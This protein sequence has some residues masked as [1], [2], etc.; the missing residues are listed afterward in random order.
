MK[1]IEIYI[2]DLP[3]YKIV[4]ITPEKISMSVKAIDHV[5]NQKFFFLDYIGSI[6]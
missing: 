3:A 6:E 2:E 4:F 5:K 1:S